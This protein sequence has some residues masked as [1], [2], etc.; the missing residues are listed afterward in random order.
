MEKFD[1]LP[2][3]SLFSSQ[4]FCG[5][6][7]HW[8]TTYIVSRSSCCSVLKV[9]TRLQNCLNPIFS[10]FWAIFSYFWPLAYLEY[11]AAWWKWYNICCKSMKS[12]TTKHLGAKYWFSW[13]KIDCFHFQ[14]FSCIFPIKT[15][16]NHKWLRGKEN[17][18]KKLWKKIRIVFISVVRYRQNVNAIWRK[19]VIMKH[20]SA[21]APKMPCPSRHWRSRGHCPGST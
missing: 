11:W 4:M 3:K 9:Y 10:S 18:V 6:R 8:F 19:S 5:K 7:F 12:L 21:Y 15:H 2:W 16:T 14:P 1:F 17:D 20:P 13:K